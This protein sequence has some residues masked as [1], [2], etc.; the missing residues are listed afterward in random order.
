[1]TDLTKMWDAL[2]QYQQFAD[3][4]GHGESWAVMCEERTAEAAEAACEGAAKVADVM[5][6]AAAAAASASAAVATNAADATYW[7]GNAI[8]LIERAIKERNHD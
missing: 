7:F 6:Y 8:N 4:D 5:T 2:A 1:M 3:A